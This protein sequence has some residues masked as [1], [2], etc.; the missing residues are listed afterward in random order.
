MCKPWH[1]RF[2]I[3]MYGILQNLNV[4][5]HRD[6]LQGKAVSVKKWSQAKGSISE[7]PY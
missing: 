4:H 6:I 3:G 5:N 1:I 2:E 7:I